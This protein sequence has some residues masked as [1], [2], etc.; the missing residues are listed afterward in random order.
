MNLKTA[1]YIKEFPE[2]SKQTHCVYHEEVSLDLL[3]HNS[4]DVG[5]TGKY[6]LEM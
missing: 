2:H 3:R 5:Y 4:E 1:N 6:S